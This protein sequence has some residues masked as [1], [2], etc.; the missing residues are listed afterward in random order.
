M[1]NP[2]QKNQKAT[3][4]TLVTGAIIWPL[5]LFLKSRRK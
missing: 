5:C 3:I 4:V 2:L 1:R